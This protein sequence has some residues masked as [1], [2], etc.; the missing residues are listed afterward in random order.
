M[1]LLRHVTEHRVY[2]RKLSTECKKDW[3][4][5]TKG[6]VSIH[7]CETEEAERGS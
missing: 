4:E 6:L 7:S 5:M 2:L 3:A 1:E